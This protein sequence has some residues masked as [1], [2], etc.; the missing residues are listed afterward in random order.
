MEEAEKKMAAER[1]RIEELERQA[2]EAHKAE[3][4]RI[5]AEKKRKWKKSRM[6]DDVILSEDASVHSDPSNTQDHHKAEASTSD[7]AG[8]EPEDICYDQ[9]QG[10]E[11]AERNR[12]P[13][14]VAPS[15]T[16]SHLDLNNLQGGV[17]DSLFQRDSHDST[18]SKEDEDDSDPWTVAKSQDGHSKAFEMPSSSEIWKSPKQGKNR[19]LP[20]FTFDKDDDSDSDREE[21]LRHP[22]EDDDEKPLSRVLATKQSPGQDH[23]TTPRPR[24]RSR[25]KSDVGSLL[26]LEADLF[27]G[28]QTSSSSSD[29]SEDEP[30]APRTLRQVAK[31]GQTLTHYDMPGSPSPAPS[32]KH[33]SLPPD[34]DGRSSDDDDVPLGYQQGKMM[35]LQ[36]EDDADDEDI[37][38][39]ARLAG[40]IAPSQIGYEQQQQQ[41]YA[42]QIALQQQA[43]YMAAQQQQMMFQA[44][45]QQQQQQWLAAMQ[46]HAQAEGSIMGAMAQPPAGQEKLARRV[47]DWRAGIE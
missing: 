29:D 35:R 5:K 17:M 30:E 2:R 34:G 7:P 4:E 8:F 10:E 21:Q 16:L 18:S 15:L 27:K 40:R 28:D 19:A 26:G 3:K 13:T 39:G 32:A 44:M 23:E 1:A 33:A 42:E 36:G 20:K 9:Q 38:L 31:T 6:L 41:A 37:P 45:M 11:L 47:D 12:R 46:Q 25:T 24:T 14:S 22:D 43:A